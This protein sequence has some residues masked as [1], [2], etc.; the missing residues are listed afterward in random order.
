MGDLFK[1]VNPDV[2]G[3]VTYC[4]NCPTYW[5]MVLDMLAAGTG[6]RPTLE[7]LVP[8]TNLREGAVVPETIDIAM[9]P[10]AIGGDATTVDTETG[11]EDEMCCRGRKHPKLSE[12]IKQ[13]E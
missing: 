9:L 8:G 10:K 12:M 13:V 6:W 2:A 5:K 1:R 11:E 7:I 4:V 3:K